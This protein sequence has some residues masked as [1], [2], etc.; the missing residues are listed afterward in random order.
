MNIEAVDILLVEDNPGDV[1]LTK[2]AFERSRLLNRLHVVSDG[3]AALDFIHQR[4]VHKQAP[5]PALI[6]LDINLPKVDGH[7]VLQEIKATPSLRQIPIVMLTSSEA[8]EDVTASYEAHANSYV[9]K[10]PTLSDLTNAVRELEDYWFALV[11]RPE[12]PHESKRLT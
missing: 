4:G 5:R 1:L 8:P 6:L 11:K 9:T 12:S 2:K 3:E 10:P 7:E